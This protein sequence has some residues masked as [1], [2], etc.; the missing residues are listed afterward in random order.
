MRYCCI[1]GS[2]RCGGPRRVAAVIML[3]HPPAAASLCCGHLNGRQPRACQTR[4][5]HP[6]TRPANLLHVG[7]FRYVISRT[8]TLWLDSFRVNSFEY[9]SVVGL[10]SCSI[11][12]MSWTFIGFH[13]QVHSICLSPMVLT[14]TG[15]WLC[16]IGTAPD[17]SH[18]LLSRFL[19][20][21]HIHVHSI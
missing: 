12:L 8:P 15:V 18:G 13:I 5:G 10:F 2:T 9:T 14:S 6:A 11:D 3:W 16:P 7:W 21:F 1:P 17:S 20:C 19:N 4:V